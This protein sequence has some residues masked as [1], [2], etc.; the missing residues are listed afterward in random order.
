MKKLR[1]MLLKDYNYEIVNFIDV[2]R[3]VQNIKYMLGMILIFILA[4][5]LYILNIEFITGIVLLVLFV[6][7]FVIPLHLIN[8]WVNDSYVVTEA[9]LI[10]H[11]NSWKYYVID[12]DRVSDVLLKNDECLTFKFEKKK[13]KI[14]FDKYDKDL[15]FLITVFEAK[16]FL[17]I[18]GEYLERPI[19]LEIVDDKMII[20]E[21]DEIETPT[22]RLVGS[23]YDNYDCVTPSYLNYILLR[24]SIVNEATIVDGSLYIKINHLEVKVDHPENVSHESV[25]A[26]DCILVFEDIEDIKCFQKPSNVRGAKN[27]L[28]YSDLADIP[29]ILYLA[30]ISDSFIE[31]EEGQKIF[32][33]ISSQGV[34]TN[35]IV[36]KYKEVIVGWKDNC[37]KPDYDSDEISMI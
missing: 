14:K 15:K 23:L 19:E 33:L 11:D 25:Q 9:Y 10:R 32:R 24:N 18:D 31:D 28:L 34:L 13:Y 29:R 21:L 36:I 2:K 4:V 7:F 16:G 8:I 30:V 17:K 5:V 12:Y 35:T 1:K 22:Q 37:D 26:N 20:I 3:I 27:E 6:F